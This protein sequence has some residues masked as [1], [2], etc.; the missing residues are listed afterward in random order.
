MNILMGKI[1][2]TFLALLIAAA[3]LPV[4]AETELEI[5]GMEIKSK[6]EVLRLIGGRL[7][8]IRKKEAS[9]WRANDAAFMV[10]EI[11]R[12]DGFYEA[13]VRGRVDSP[14]RIT[15]IVDEGQRLSLGTVTMTGDGDAEALE[16]TFK[17]PFEG[18][19]PFGAGS[20][21]FRADD[22][23]TALNF[24]TRQL[25]S[26]G[27]WSVEVTMQKQ[28]IDKETGEVDMTVNVDQGRSLP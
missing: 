17:S 28:T 19:T 9:S 24:V 5:R 6:S 14:D 8:Y 12:E 13:T 25:Q 27:Y 7:V 4:S 15:L 2:G 10:Q 11:L 18:S 20:P 22:V 1:S 23:P 3:L 21:P 16:E 26:E